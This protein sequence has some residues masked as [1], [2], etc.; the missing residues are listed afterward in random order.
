MSRSFVPYSHLSLFVSLPHE[1]YFLT[2]SSYDSYLHHYI[3]CPFL[4]V[5]PFC[6]LSSAP[7]QRGLAPSSGRAYSIQYVDHH[8]SLGRCVFLCPLAVGFC[9][10][11]LVIG[12][13]SH[14]EH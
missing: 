11:C 13:L 4:S 14:T 1:S 12:S 3:L 6:R 10:F 8:P 2:I 7:L 9:P 5:H